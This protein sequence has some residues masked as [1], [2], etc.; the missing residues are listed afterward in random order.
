MSRCGRCFNAG[1]LYKLAS[2]LAKGPCKDEFR[3]INDIIA[4]GLA[5]YLVVH[6]LVHEGWTERDSRSV[7]ARCR[8]LQVGRA[9]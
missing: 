6:F 4:K 8:R 2:S 3:N 9:T 1:I 5:L 7:G